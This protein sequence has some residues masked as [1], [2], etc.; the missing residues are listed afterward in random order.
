M[1][2]KS[3]SCPRGFWP[4]FKG[5]SFDIWTPDT[6]S[7]YAWADPK[8]LLTELQKKR[9]ASGRKKDSPFS[10]FDA[11]RLNDRNTLPC[12]NPRIAFRDVTRS[13]DS[14]TVRVA[15]IPPN[16][17][18][19][20]KGPFFLWPRG[21]VSDQAY[22]LGVLSSI[23]LDWYARRFVEISLNYYVLNPFP[24]PRPARADPLR[25]R[26]VA[27]AGRLACPDERFGPWAEAA[28]VAYG[29][30]AE[31]DRDD[32]VCE[33]DAVA[34]LLYGLDERHVVHVFE[35]FHEGWDPGP[36]LAAVLSHFRRWRDRT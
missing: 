9:L 2:L 24:I 12:L 27:L 29:P 26:V 33:L 1:D 4:V 32:K 18:V 17:F 10:E 13:T 11:F 28:G 7:Y 16:V 22:L 25:Q 8:A 35:T 3:E 31:D 30:L 5:E 34:A 15:L 21:D 20:N 19:T 14:R 23:P 36:R 6:G